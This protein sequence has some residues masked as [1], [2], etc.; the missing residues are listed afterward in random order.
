MICWA[1]APAVSVVLMSYLGRFIFPFIVL[2]VPSGFLKHATPSTLSLK[3][4][5]FLHPVV[6]HHGFYSSTVFRTTLLGI[7]N[8]FSLSIP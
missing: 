1:V 2:C 8:K 4:F 6:V 5:F 7:L 3:L